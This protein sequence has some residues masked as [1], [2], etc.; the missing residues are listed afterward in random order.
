MNAAVSSVCFRKPLAYV[1]LPE[2]VVAEAIMPVHVGVH[3]HRPVDIA[4]SGHG[5]VVSHLARSPYAG[6][7]AVTRQY[8]H[9]VRSPLDVERVMRDADNGSPFVGESSRER[10]DL[11]V[12]KLVKTARHLVEENDRG[13]MADLVG[14]TDSLELSAAEIADSSTLP[15][16]ES[17]FAYE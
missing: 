11:E 5:E 3:S 2:R 16:L 1:P 10:H 7:S 13:P 12:P 4:E 9:T 17:R 15:M 14:K 6:E 8:D